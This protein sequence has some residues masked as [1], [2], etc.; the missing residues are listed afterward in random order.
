MVALGVVCWQMV[1]QEGE[2]V[3]IEVPSFYFPGT[4]L[5]LLSPQGYAK[6]HDLS[7]K[8]EFGGNGDTFWMNL[9]DHPNCIRVPI[10]P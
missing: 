5:R 9:V 10:D 7:R 2:T 6:Y 8:T 4:I 1:S 3:N